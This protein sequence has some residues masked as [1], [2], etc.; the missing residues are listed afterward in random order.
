LFASGLQL[1]IW[2]L[3]R[4]NP[5]PPKKR[6]KTTSA[7]DRRSVAKEVCDNILSQIKE[8][9]DFKDRLSAAKLFDFVNF[10]DYY[11]QKFPQDYF[12]AK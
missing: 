8:R 7:G 10:K 3:E 11:R 1:N 2:N 9:F 4:K 12:D 5:P 6:Q